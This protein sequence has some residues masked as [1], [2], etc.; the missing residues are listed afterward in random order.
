MTKSQYTLL[1]IILLFVVVGCG[2]T[3]EDF[4][5]L[6][7][8]TVVASEPDDDGFVWQTEQFADLKIVRYQIPG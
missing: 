3:S 2:P 1:A 7:A 5:S 6:E 8:T 4:Q